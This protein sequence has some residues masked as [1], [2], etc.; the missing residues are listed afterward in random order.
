MIP[1]SEGGVLS[2]HSRESAASSGRSGHVGRWLPLAAAG[3]IVV[4]VWLMLPPLAFGSYLPSGFC[5]AT[6]ILIGVVLLRSGRR[7]EGVTIFVTSAVAA[8]FLWWLTSVDPALLKEVVV[9]Q[10]LAAATIALATPIAFAALGGVVCERS[11]VMNIGLEGM[12]LMGA[13]FAVVGADLTR[14]WVAGLAS[15]VLAGGMLGL[16]FAAFVVLLGG[17]QIV[18][19]VA[20]NFLA[21]GLTGYLYLSWYADGISADLPAIPRVAL[22]TEGLGP[23]GEL[24]SGLNL[25]VWLCLALVLGLHWFLFSSAPG[26]RLRAIG[27]LPAAADTAGI[28]VQT[29]RLIATMVSG[30]IAAMGGVFLS[31]GYVNGFNENMTAGRG[32]IALAAMIFGGWRPFNA[33]GAALL[34]GVASAIAL[35]I[36]DMSPSTSA[37]FHAAPYLVTIIAVAGIVGRVSAPAAIGVAYQR[38]KR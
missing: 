30:M 38:R 2:T 14:S 22:P 32:Y 29:T 6:A 5:I 19:G 12:M 28:R 17:N 23:L 34:F 35:R 3:A 37:L 10:P 1:R 20:V 13:F 7:S 18:A 26:L 25:M 36:P 15:G 16:L 8:M 24:L 9:W 11:G 31:L 33:L 4:A 21:L 27:E